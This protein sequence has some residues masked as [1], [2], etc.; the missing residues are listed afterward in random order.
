MIRIQ[1]ITT[2]W[3]SAMESWI[4]DVR[5]KEIVC[6]LVNQSCRTALLRNLWVNQTMPAHKACQLSCQS[7]TGG[8]WTRCFVFS[9][10]TTVFFW[11]GLLVNA[12]IESC[13]WDKDISRK[14]DKDNFLK[15]WFLY[16]FGENELWRLQALIF[17]ATCHW[18]YSRHGA[19][20][21]FLLLNSYGF[22]VPEFDQP[23]NKSN[24]GRRITLTVS[25]HAS[26]GS[27]KHLK[28]RDVTIRG[29]LALPGCLQRFS[30]CSIL[31]CLASR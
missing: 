21:C 30:H 27:W 25:G 17:P 24:T 12:F 5:I 28:M 4:L 2:L 16:I 8:F 10:V 1:I 3:F 31:Q 22:V 15:Y 20:R 18:E 11:V 7:V 13:I 23:Q 26:L 6:K 19:F 9:S 29:V 14:L